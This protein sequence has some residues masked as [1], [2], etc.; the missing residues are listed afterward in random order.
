MRWWWDIAF[1]LL[2]IILPWVDWVSRQNDGTC[3]GGGPPSYFVIL[4]VGDHRA[5]FFRWGTT[6]LLYSSE[7]A[8][9]LDC[10]SFSMA[11]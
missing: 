5:T 4:S 6:E 7:D 2:F 8:I 3:F 1:I 10:S 11:R 9:R